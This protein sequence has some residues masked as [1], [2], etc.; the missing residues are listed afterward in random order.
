MAKRIIYTA[1]PLA[2]RWHVSLLI[3]TG[4]T[5][6]CMCASAFSQQI[7]FKVQTVI[8]KKIFLF[9]KTLKTQDMPK[10][11]VVYTDATTS[12][13]DVVIEEFTKLGVNV[14]A[15][16]N[17]QISTA[18]SNYNIIFILPGCTNAKNAARNAGILS[19]CSDPTL[20]ERG[21]YS[22]ALADENGKPKIVV[23]TGSLKA[24]GQEL[25]SELLKISRIIQ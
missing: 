17:S 3:A 6:L 16:K 21:D 11:L 24:E 25:S 19:I 23:N 22:I 4:I 9:V 13:K 18:I 1:L 7:P 20:V 10:V 2:L 15:V 14:G 8:F 5:M 12:D